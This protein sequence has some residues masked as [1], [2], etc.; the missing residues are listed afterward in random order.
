MRAPP[1]KTRDPMHSTTRTQFRVCQEI[2]TPV[3]GIRKE[4]ER[5]RF[6]QHK[7]AKRVTT[8]LIIRTLLEH[9]GVLATP[10][11]PNGAQRH[12]DVMRF[13]TEARDKRATDA[14]PHKTPPQAVGAT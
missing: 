5:Y 3:E 6:L 9:V 1:E 10:S 14:P 13:V 2:Y 12:I 8:E 4:Y 11:D 7:D